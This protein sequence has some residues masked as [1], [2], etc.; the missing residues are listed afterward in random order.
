MRALY[1][2]FI[3]M[4]LCIFSTIAA[5]ADERSEAAAAAQEI[6]KLFGEKKYVKIWETHMSESVQ[7]IS[8]RDHFLSNV[9]MSRSSLGQFSS[10][11]IINIEYTTFDPVTKV[12]GAIYAVTFNSMYTIGQVYDR[13]V[14]VKDVDGRF[15]L[16]GWWAVPAPKQ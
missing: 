12:N 1:T 16:G 2:L 11:E 15:R 13:I 5:V 9:T 10:A 6:L 7:R 3:L 8:S 14:V 4:A